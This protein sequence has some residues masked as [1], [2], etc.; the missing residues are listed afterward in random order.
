MRENTDKN[1]K[2]IHD[3][4]KQVALLEQKLELQTR[5]MG[6]L[7]A[8]MD[9]RTDAGRVKSAEIKQLQDAV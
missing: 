2:T 4:K 1:V 8:Q 6:N 3:Y 7:E 5:S 9:S